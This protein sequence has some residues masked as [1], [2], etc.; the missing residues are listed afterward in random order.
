MECR[1]R[2]VYKNV[3]FL[4]TGILIDSSIQLRLLIIVV[5]FCVLIRLECDRTEVLPIFSSFIYRR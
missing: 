2:C 3:R 1:G 5:V 4:R